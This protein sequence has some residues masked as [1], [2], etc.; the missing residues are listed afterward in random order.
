MIMVGTIK[1]GFCSAETV[2]N[3]WRQS[4]RETPTDT[5]K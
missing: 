2:E 5:V 3:A 4:E 1:D